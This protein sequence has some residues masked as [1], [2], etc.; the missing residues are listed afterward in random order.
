[1][2][3][4]PF[5][6]ERLEQA[7]KKRN[8][9]W[10]SGVR[11][12]G[13]TVLAQSIRGIEYLDCERPRVRTAIEDDPEGFLE[14]MKGKRIVLD[15]IH[16]LARPS[17]ILKLAADHYGDVRVIATGSSTL[18]ATRKFRD[19]LTGRKETLWLTPMI[20]PDMTAFG[21]A[22]LKH[23][24]LHGGLPPFFLSKEHPEEQARAWM[25]AYWAR[26]V[27][28]LFRV[29]RRD[30]FLRFAELLLL[31]SG[32]MF[33]ASRFTGPCEVSRGTI[34]N[35][36]TALEETYL[37]H[38]IRPF[39][40]R[41][42]VEIVKAPKVY[43]FDTGFLCAERGW[44]ELREEDCGILWEHLVLNELMAHLQ[45]RRIHYW[46]DKRG[47]EVD[48]ILGDLSN[49]PLIAIECKWGRGNLDDRSMRAFL[50]HYPRTRMIVVQPH[51]PVTHT[52]RLDNTPI[53]VT[54]LKT[55]TEKIS[56]N[57]RNHASFSELRS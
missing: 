17:E 53:T 54:D 14:S 12:V 33:E 11:R 43:G 30:S 31:Q 49:R 28:E 22:N 29:E 52:F 46:R 41:K 51:E 3:Q 4:R 39:S 8:V 10:L 25:D 57:G 23:R 44:R 24:F 15:E 56:R 32:G 9:V 48:F 1:M 55:L 40:S 27:Q 50:Q 47:H 20:L 45:T 6:R 16:R 36:L 19:A 37:V 38:R 13:K 2:V 34:Q 21:N 26:D 35:Y 5:W 42:S 7:L 18:A